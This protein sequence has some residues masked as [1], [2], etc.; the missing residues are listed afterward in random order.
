MK[1][2]QESETL[3]KGCLFSFKSKLDCKIIMVVVLFFYL[4]CKSILSPKVSTTVLFSLTD[5][6][7]QSP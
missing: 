6:L 1:T 2:T 3:P 5:G 7:F 4:Y